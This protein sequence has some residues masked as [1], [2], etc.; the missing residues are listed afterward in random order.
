MV[1]TRQISTRHWNQFAK[2]RDGSTKLFPTQVSNSRPS[3]FFRSG[4]SEKRTIRARII[5]RCLVFFLLNE[6]KQNVYSTL[7]FILSSRICLSSCWARKGKILSDFTNVRKSYSSSIFPRLLSKLF[8]IFLHWEGGEGGSGNFNYYDFK[9]SFFLSLSS[10]ST[11]D[12]TSLTVGFPPLV[13]CPPFDQPNLS[14][15]TW[16]TCIYWLLLENNKLI[17]QLT[18]LS[19]RRSRDGNKEFFFFSF[20]L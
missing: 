14:P 10:R 8:V 9:E 18:L 4:S 13:D 17:R 3:E 16:Y 15:S 2:N 6:R 11:T 12:C 19:T 20:T 5:S 7:E 1:V